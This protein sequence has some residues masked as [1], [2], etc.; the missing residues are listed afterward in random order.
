MIGLQ[1]RREHVFCAD[2][3]I[4]GRRHPDLASSKNQIHIAHDLGDPGNHFAGHSPAC[5]HQ[6]PAV[7][8]VTENPLPHLLDR[9][10]LD[11]AVDRFI[12]II[13]NDPRHR[14][15]LVGHHGMLC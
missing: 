11:R 2:R 5:A 7:C 4:A 13:L 8:D 14:I 15:L 6:R 1:S 12:D 10:V 3:G 9:S